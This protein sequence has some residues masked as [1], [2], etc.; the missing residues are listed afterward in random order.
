MRWERETWRARARVYCL[1]MHDHDR[2]HT[3]TNTSIV[4]IRVHVCTVAMDIST[5]ACRFI[6]IHCSCG[7]LLCSHLSFD[8]NP[9][10][11]WCTAQ[12]HCFCFTNVIGIAHC[13][14]A[15]VSGQHDW[16][17]RLYRENPHNPCILAAWFFQHC[18]QH[19]WYID[20]SV[21]GVFSLAFS[22]PLIK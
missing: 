18:F 7:Y 11:A 9:Y 22:R 3:N 19:L 15:Q 13:S 4:S 6:V 20:Y 2:S 12:W 14:V 17:V 1:Q 21:V 5:P 16:P 10:M 8:R